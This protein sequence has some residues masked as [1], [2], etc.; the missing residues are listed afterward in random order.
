M[1]VL[2]PRLAAEGVRK[3]SDLS[4]GARVGTSSLRRACQLKLVCTEA[5]VLPL[6]GNIDTR[7]RKVRQGEY[8]AIIL[9][10]AGLIRGGIIDSADSPPS[11]QAGQDMLALSVDEMLPSPGQA[12]LALQCRSDDAR[13][14]RLLSVLDDPDTRLAVE[15]ER[16]LIRLLG[17]DC[18][19]P[20]AAYAKK[21][22]TTAASSD[23]PD[24]HRLILR[25]NVFS[26]GG[27][28]KQTE[29]KPDYL[30]GTAANAA[31]LFRA[32]QKSGRLSDLGYSG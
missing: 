30:N 3:L 9:A 24:T 19:S 6:R 32:W 13:T 15:Q 20:I 11:Y 28:H 18:H 14:R 12:A 25:A 5:H 22:D 10:A 8:D 29:N 31:D 26:S 27:H 17:G 4:P 16:E 7:L 23:A 2:S 1:L 21:S